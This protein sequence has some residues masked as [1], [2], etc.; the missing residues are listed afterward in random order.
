[1]FIQVVTTEFYR[2][3]LKCDASCE[4]EGDMSHTPILPRPN[5]RMGQRQQAPSP[6]ATTA[7][8]PERKRKPG[9]GGRSS[10]LN[11]W[12]VT[13]SSTLLWGGDLGRI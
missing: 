8:W 2:T 9:A 6:N 5:V 13:W 7:E 3:I 12:H 11:S 1:M 10:H 4:R